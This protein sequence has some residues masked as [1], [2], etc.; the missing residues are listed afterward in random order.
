MRT[1]KTWRDPYGMGWATTKRKEVEFKPGVTVLCGCNGIGK[2]TLLRNIRSQLKEEKIP[3]YYFDNM[4]DGGVHSINEMALQ[5]KYGMVANM[6]C[7]S[8]GENIS[9]N[10]G[11][12]VSKL[13]KFIIDGDTGSIVDKLAKFFSRDLNKEEIITTKERWIL[14]D[15]IDSGY[16][17]D[18]VIEL[19]NLFNLMLD[20][21]YKMGYEVYIIVSAN[22][23]E[24]AANMNCLDVTEGKYVTFDDYDVF[25]KFII[26]SREKKDKIRTK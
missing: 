19:K 6:V 23:Y 7:S 21:A 4:R 1:I 11:I 24:L 15:A 2:T 26:K 20:D 9:N 5:E 25:K 17:I 18:N 10:I 13:R 12:M 22:E 8:E 3:Y 14:L 16:S